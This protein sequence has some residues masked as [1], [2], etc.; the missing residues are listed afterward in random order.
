MYAE[1]VMRDA[2]TAVPRSISTNHSA[3]PDSASRFVLY[4]R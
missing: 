1:T 3:M 4:V 2:T